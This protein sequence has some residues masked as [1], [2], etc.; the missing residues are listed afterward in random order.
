[1]FRAF[2]AQVLVVMLAEEHA[3]RLREA[4]LANVLALAQR[5]VP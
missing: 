3:G 5:A 1:M 4:R 2:M